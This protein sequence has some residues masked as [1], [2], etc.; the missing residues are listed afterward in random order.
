MALLSSTTSKSKAQ[1]TKEL[2]SPVSYDGGSAG[3]IAHQKTKLP[4]FWGNP[5]RILQSVASAAALQN[6]STLGITNAKSAATTEMHTANFI[7]SEEVDHFPLKALSSRLKKRPIILFKPAC[8][9]TQIQ[10]LSLT[11]RTLSHH[12]GGRIQGMYSENLYLPC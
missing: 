7:C 12:Q 5:R 3:S 9:W 8:L 2:F 4:K 6:P 11:S 10:N 1:V